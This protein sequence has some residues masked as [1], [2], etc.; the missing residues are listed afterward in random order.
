MTKRL[1]E[2]FTAGGYHFTPCYGSLDSF[3]G[4]NIPI[5]Y[6]DV[7]EESRYLG[8]YWVATRK[9]TRTFMS[10]SFFA[11]LRSES[12]AKDWQL[13]YPDPGHA[14]FIGKGSGFGPDYDY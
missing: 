13:K 5:H 2:E 1:S 8:T 3:S 14:L 9:I 10:E 6:F 7:F 4:S 11:F 12:P